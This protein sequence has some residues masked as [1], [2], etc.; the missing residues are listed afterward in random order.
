M[1]GENKILL[2]DDERL[3]LRSIE[4]TLL[5]AGFDV[6]TAQDTS[7]GLS[8]FEAA[9]TDSEPFD[10]AILDL[11][12]PN[13]EGQSDPNAGLE[14]LSKL[15]EMDADLL[16]VVLTAFDQ[17]GRA[18][19]AVARGACTYFVKGREAELVEIVN[20]ITS[21]RIESVL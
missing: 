15:L 5:R 21:E 2:V 8:L 20:S 1:T 6:E 13:L 12:M 18:K 3:V 19:E 16:I 14:L 9:L 17:V 10:V 11:H 7:A 4:K